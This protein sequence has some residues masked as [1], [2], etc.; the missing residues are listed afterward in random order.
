MNVS[1]LQVREQGSNICSSAANLRLGLLQLASTEQPA[2]DVSWI[3][4]PTGFPKVGSTSS[5]LRDL[6]MAPTG[7]EKEG[8]E[9][10]KEQVL[11]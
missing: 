4:L 8:P 10:Q 1:S 6:V 11:L 5:V 9:L 2:L 3:F 7:T